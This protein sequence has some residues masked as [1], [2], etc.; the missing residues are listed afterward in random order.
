MDERKMVFSKRKEWKMAQKNEEDKEKRV[1]RKKTEKEEK[2]LYEKKKKR[3]PHPYKYS[4]RY[5]HSKT[6]RP[7]SLSA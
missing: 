4:P 1:D 7:I 3:L 5:S 6:T 2:R